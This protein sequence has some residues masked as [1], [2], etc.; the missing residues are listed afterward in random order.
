MGRPTIGRLGPFVGGMNNS[1]NNPATIADTEL[2]D[3]LNMDVDL[4]GSLKMRPPIQ[5]VALTAPVTTTL[6]GGI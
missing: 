6:V 5:E 3:C 1:T 4:D 2:W